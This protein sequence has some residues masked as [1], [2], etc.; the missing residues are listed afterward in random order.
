[1]VHASGMLHCLRPAVPYRAFALLAHLAAFA[2]IATALVSPAAASL[3]PV[4]GAPSIPFTP[5]A[6]ANATGR[7]TYQHG[8]EFV[9]IG[10]VGNTPWQGNGTPGDRAIGRG[11]V[12]YEYR[13][14]RY[15]VTTAQWAEFFTAA[16]ARPANDRLPHITAPRFWGGQVDPTYRGPG[17]RYIPRPGQELRPVGDISWRMAAMYCNWLHNDKSTE[18]SAFLSGAY[19][20]STFS[21]GT[22]FN[23]QPTRSPDARFF[24]PTLDETLKASHWDPNRFGPDQG[25]WWLFN[26]ATNEPLFGGPP[27]GIG[28]NPNFEFGPSQAN[29]TWLGEFDEQF[30]VPLGAYPMTQTPWGLLDA[31]G[32]TSEWTEEVVR[33]TGVPNYR[34]FEGSSWGTFTGLADRIVTL[35][36]SDFPSFAFPEYGLRVAASIPS[37]AGGLLLIAAT[38]S[39]HAQRKRKH[40]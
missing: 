37:P 14:G 27:G 34:I 28:E 9:S 20:V 38:F 31:S 19:D 32:A 35:N 15:E 30:E 11:Q 6:A 10:D 33:V 16:F 13:I 5:T 36:T 40:P 24:I 4:P 23:D 21:Y 25:G 12:N 2:S 8:I 17:T 39:L 7:V 29:H 18:R 22:G 26:N 3:T 1:M